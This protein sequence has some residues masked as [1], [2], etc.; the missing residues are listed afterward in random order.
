MDGPPAA[1]LHF[2]QNRVSMG[3]SLNT[4]DAGARCI[5]NV[6]IIYDGL[7]AGQRGM[8]LFCPSAYGRPL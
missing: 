2:M 8:Q 7:A 6:I 1:F 5:F 4:S 3:S